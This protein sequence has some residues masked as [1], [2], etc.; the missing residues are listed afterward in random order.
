MT[1]QDSRP[2]N[3]DYAKR[4]RMSQRPTQGDPRLPA[5]RQLRNA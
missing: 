1:R 5:D 3:L 4:E 2:R